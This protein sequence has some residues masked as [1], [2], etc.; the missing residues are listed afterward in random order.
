MSYSFTV[1]APRS[2]LR[3]ELGEAVAKVEQTDT[4]VA[5]ERGQQLVAFFNAIDELAD[6]IGQPDDDIFVSVTGHA[7]PGHAPR[8]GWADEFITISVAARPRAEALVSH[9]P[10]PE[11]G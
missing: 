11:A 6:A 4:G 1:T 2:T 9:H 3:N 8:D 10:E 7:N 5:E